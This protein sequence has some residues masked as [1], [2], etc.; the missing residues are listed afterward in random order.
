MYTGK[1]KKPDPQQPSVRELAA[2]REE[3]PAAGPPSGAHT[4]FFTLSKIRMYNLVCGQELAP[5]PLG[6]EQERTGH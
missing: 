3:D 2:G 1:H 6:S 4:I 5:A